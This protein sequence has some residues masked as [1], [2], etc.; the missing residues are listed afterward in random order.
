MNRFSMQIAEIC[1]SSLSP[2]WHGH[3]FV[4][5][6]YVFSCFYKSKFLLSP[7]KDTIGKIWGDLKKLI[8]PIQISLKIDPT[9]PIWDISA[10]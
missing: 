6:W 9:A 2:G 3:G 8:M 7:Y 1:F 10:W 5:R 4:I